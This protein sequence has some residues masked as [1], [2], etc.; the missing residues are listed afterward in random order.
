M[1]LSVIQIP[2]FP[3]YKKPLLQAIRVWKK[4]G[5]GFDTLATSSALN[6]RQTATVLRKKCLVKKKPQVWE[7]FSDTPSLIDRIKLESPTAH[8]A[9][10]CTASEQRALL[11]AF[12][13]SSD[14]YSLTPCGWIMIELDL[15]TLQGC[16]QGIINPL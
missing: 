11:E 12:K 16:I 7:A 15:S 8:L 1:K 10:V 5:V 9:L 13:L 3:L 14:F 4:T 2:L 6:S